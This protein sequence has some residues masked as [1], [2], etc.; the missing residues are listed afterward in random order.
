MMM[1]KAINR[2]LAKKAMKRAQRQNF[3]SNSFE[4]PDAV[5]FDPFNKYH[6][7]DV[8]VTKSLWNNRD[9]MLNGIGPTVGG[10]R[11]NVFSDNFLPM[12][13]NQDRAMMEMADL[14][15]GAPAEVIVLDEHPAAPVELVD[16][17]GGSVVR[18]AADMGNSLGA[19]IAS[20]DR[21][22]NNDIGKKDDYSYTSIPEGARITHIGTK[23]D[24]NNVHL[25]AQPADQF[26]TAIASNDRALG[27]Q[28][29][30]QAGAPQDT[31]IINEAQ[32]G[33]HGL[34]ELAPSQDMQ[35]GA[36]IASNDRMIG[37][38]VRQLF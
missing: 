10:D 14:S 36:A 28:L 9:F 38:Q 20:N 33:G 35:M 13:N 16:M 5:L 27:Q 19:A 11:F 18:D 12:A 8:D 21:A 24:S 4:K 22:I 7:P 15:A 29:T 31:L 26:N 23:D 6:F 32:L 37:S 3:P 30:S 2:K 34:F 1:N 17:V 25:I